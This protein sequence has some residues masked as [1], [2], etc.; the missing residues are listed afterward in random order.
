MGRYIDSS[1]LEGHSCIVLQ[2]EFHFVLD[3]YVIFGFPLT[4][5]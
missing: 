4:R 5:Q 3:R 1:G 2:S